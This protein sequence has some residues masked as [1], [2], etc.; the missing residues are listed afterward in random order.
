MAVGSGAEPL[1]IEKLKLQG[2]RIRLPTG[3]EDEPHPL[4]FFFNAEGLLLPRRV[5]ASVPFDS[6]R[7][8]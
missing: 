2:F 4:L 1:L 8:R 5:I 3:V 6:V 7:L